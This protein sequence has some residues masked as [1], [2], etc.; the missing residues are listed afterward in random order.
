[1]ESV[2]SWLHWVIKDSLKAWIFAVVFIR[3]DMAFNSQHSKSQILTSPE[4]KLND[5]AAEVPP[6][7]ALEAP[8][9]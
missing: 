5:F 1:M 4:A 8:N 6:A 3:L 9:L 2:A 7:E